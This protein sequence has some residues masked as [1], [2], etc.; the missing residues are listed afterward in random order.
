MTTMDINYQLVP[1]SNHISKNADRAI[2][3]FKKHF[4]VVLYSV[5]A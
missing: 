2:Q 1:P 4:I 5:D 3:T